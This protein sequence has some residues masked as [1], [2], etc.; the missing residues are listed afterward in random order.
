MPVFL[1]H[2]ELQGFRCMFGLHD[3][4]RYMYF[5]DNRLCFGVS[6]TPAIFNCLS[7]A[8]VH[9]MAKRG[10]HSIVNYLDNFLILG[11]TKAECHQGLKQPSHLTRLSSQ[12][13]ADILWWKKFIFTFNGRSMMLDF[14]PNG[15]VLSRFRCRMLG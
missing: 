13:H 2:R 14:C 7:N 8:V 15:L 6:C 1:P 12:F 9:M 11:K 10:F 5:V 4:S 3:P